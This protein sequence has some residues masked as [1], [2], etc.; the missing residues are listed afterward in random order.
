MAIL[1]KAIRRVIYNK[2]LVD[3]NTLI[4]R[5]KAHI[6]YKD[7]EDNVKG[8]IWGSAFKNVYILIK[9]KNKVYKKVQM[10]VFTTN[11]NRPTLRET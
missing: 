1:L 2:S 10:T 4:C 9:A 11:I 3:K 5:E 8:V 6:R 7:K